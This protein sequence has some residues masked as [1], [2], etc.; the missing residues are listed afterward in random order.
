MKLKIKNIM[1]LSEIS[2]NINTLKVGLFVDNVIPYSSLSFCNLIN[3]DF[4]Y[5]NIEEELIE[6][7]S[8]SNIILN[9]L[10]S[11]VNWRNH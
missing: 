4:F 9:V 11:N 3:D 6:E 1:Q 7:L 5:Y 10:F 2:D 8:K